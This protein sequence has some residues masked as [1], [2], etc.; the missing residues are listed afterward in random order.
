MSKIKNP[1]LLTLDDSLSLLNK[2]YKSI[3]GTHDPIREF[4]KTHEAMGMVWLDKKI[5]TEEFGRQ[6]KRYAGYI[7]D[8]CKH[9][10]D[11]VVQLG[12]DDAEPGGDC[13]CVKAIR[14]C[15]PC[16]V[17]ALQLMDPKVVLTYEEK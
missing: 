16:V 2:N 14:L 17:S 12:D 13:S 8:G 6:W 1:Q 5:L 7:C 10:V 3:Y 9:H 15:Q 11:Q 4:A